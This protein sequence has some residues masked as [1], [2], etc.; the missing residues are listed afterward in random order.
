MPPIS[1]ALLWA[2]APRLTG[3]AARAQA[4]VLNAIAPALRPV[5]MEFDISTRLRA[6]HFLAQIAHESAG[7]R[8]TEEFASGAAYE[9]R[10]DLGNTEPG[11]GPRFKGRGLIQLTGRAN[12]RRFGAMLGMDLEGNPHQAA[13]P[14]LS[15]RIAGLFWRAHGLNAPADRDDLE[16]VTRAINGGL[17]GLADRR[18][19]LARARA[20]LAAG[21]ARAVERLGPGARGP[22][23]ARLQARLNGFGAAL[24]VDGLYGPATTLAVRAWQ[25]QNGLTADGIVGPASWAAFARAARAPDPQADA[26]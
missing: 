26:A 23:V 8:T 9:G 13:E 15:L 17:N 21:G 12:Y 22:A 10:G 7:F 16:A 14:R 24:A 20:A 18:A 4:R 1:P 5:L 6:A 19:Y 2:I 11:D 3:A 25:T